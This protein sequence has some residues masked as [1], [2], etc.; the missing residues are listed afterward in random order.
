MGTGREHHR[1]T[2]VCIKILRSDTNKAGEYEVTVT[3]ELHASAE[4]T[5]EQ[6]REGCRET[7]GFYRDAQG[8]LER[9]VGFRA[10]ERG[11][12]VREK[13]DER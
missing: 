6:K 4:R 8:G 13:G 12:F 11:W 2:I 7:L 10:R 9:R 1:G 3:S 5:K